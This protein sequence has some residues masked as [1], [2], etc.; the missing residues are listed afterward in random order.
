MILGKVHCFI[1]LNQLE[2]LVPQLVT[3]L[4]QAKKA[5]IHWLL[6]QAPKMLLSLLFVAWDPQLVG[7]HQHLVPRF[8][9]SY[10][11]LHH[12]R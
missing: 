3:T 12:P 11:S 7:Y 6:P 4:I 5:S 2:Q 9:L 1:A 8:G 10:C